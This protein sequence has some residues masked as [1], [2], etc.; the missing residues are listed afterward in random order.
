MSDGSAANKLVLLHFFYTAAGY[1]LVGSGTDRDVECA[2]CLLSGTAWDAMAWD[3]TP[4]LTLITRRSW[5]QIPS[6]PPTKRH[7]RR[8]FPQRGAPSLLRGGGRTS[9]LVSC[10]SLI[11]E[12]GDLIEQETD[13]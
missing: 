4:G 2:N 12:D 13:E 8:G 11:A 1:E 9:A 5:V 6:P 10:D 7:V 3:V